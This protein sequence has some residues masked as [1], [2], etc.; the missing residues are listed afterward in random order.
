MSL[1]LY[2]GGCDSS[3]VLYQLLKN[4]EPLTILSINHCNVGANDENK[5]H[6]EL[7]ISEM[8]ILLIY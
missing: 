7:F 8:K 3:L 1:L 6:R 4:K 5:T 2:S